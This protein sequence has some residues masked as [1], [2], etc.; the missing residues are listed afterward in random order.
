MSRCLAVVVALFAGASG[1]AAGPRSVTMDTLPTPFFIAHRGDMNVYPEHTME[2]Y[3]A[4][5]AEGAYFVEVDCFLLKDG[6][7]A[8]MHDDTLNRTANRTGAT[9]S[10]PDLAAWRQVKVDGNKLLPPFPGRLYDAPTLEDVLAE[11]GN[12]VILAVEAKGPGSGAPLVQALLR[13]GVRKD[14]V[15]VNSFIEGELA[16]ARAAGFRTSRNFLRQ[17]T[18]ADFANS[19]HDYLAFDVDSDEG[20]VQQAITAG[21]KVIIYTANRHHDRDRYLRR[22]VVG[23]YTDNSLY[24]E[25][26]HATAVARTTDPYSLQTWYQGHLPAAGTRV[27]AFEAPNRWGYSTYLNDQ[28]SGSLQGWCSPLNRGDGTASFELRLSATFGAAVADDRW[29]GILLSSSDRVVGNEQAPSNPIFGYHFI[30]TKSGVL[31]ALNYN[32]QAPTV[33]QQVDTQRPVASGETVRL[34]L[35]R[36]GDTLTFVREGTS[37]GIKFKETGTRGTY[38]TFGAKGLAVMFSDVSVAPTLTADPVVVAPLTGQ[39][40]ALGGNVTLSVSAA[41]AM[42]VSLQWRRNGVPI[43]GATGDTLA[44]RSA[45]D[46]DAGAYTVEATSFLGSVVSSPIQLTVG[47][48]VFAEASAVAV[49][50]SARVLVADALAH[51]VTRVGADNQ[52]AVVAGLA[53]ATGTTDAF[54]GAARFNQPRGVAVSGTGRIYVADSGNGLIRAIAPDGTVSTLAGSAANRGHADGA[55]AAATFNTPAAIALDAS[56]IAWVADAGSHTVRRLAADG[57]V[58]TH[59][60]GGAV[61]GDADGDRLAARFNSPAGIAV[62]PEGVLY[63]ADT[64]NHTIRRIAANGTVT[65][66]AGLAGVAGSSDGKGANALFNRPVG[67]ALDGS[68]ALI[69]ADSGN[70]TLRRV[71]PD[72][73]T[74]T[75]A[76]LPTVSGLRD[77]PA[78][79]ALFNRP[80]SVAV[81]ADGQIVVADAANGVLRRISPAGVVTT[82]PLAKATAAPLP[83]EPTTPPASSIPPAASPPSGG[84]GG[85]GG[86]GA[87]SW[88]FVLTVLTALVFRSR[89]R[90][91]P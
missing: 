32:G 33:V 78:A 54:A 12:R 7:L 21:R 52:P 22:G 38:L 80:E 37:V 29:A 6:T 91:S 55:G 43:A 64:G 2:A 56:G 1:G 17:V 8:I 53:Q 90:R 50:A 41:G 3:R 51:T 48:V 60:G 25:G 31:R 73:T 9:G 34:R 59:A 11:F 57:S 68:G 85:G 89:S 16:P 14:M 79:T 58:T 65:T 47:P 49:D 19:V 72:G 86:G 81:Q 23:F 74:S 13:H 4:S 27:G 87:P 66:L 28:Y 84:G 63:V 44:V 18:A 26:V 45:A 83:V 71:A 20:I 10:V 62:G 5:V 42:P 30:L 70:S 61:R 69:V 15:L 82:L 67:L 77:G 75:L 46:A 88:V 40:V 76:G 36:Q 39:H 24:L 35:T